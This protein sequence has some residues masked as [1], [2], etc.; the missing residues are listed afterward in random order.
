LKLTIGHIYPNLLNLY[1]DKGNITTFEKRL[2][3]REI[4]YETVQYSPGDTIE[5]SKIDILYIGACSGSRQH[6]VCGLLQKQKSNLKEY[7]K[8]GGA[9]LAIDGGY[10]LLGHY[11]KTGESLIEGLA[12][13]DMFTESGGKRAVGDS[14][15][16]S[17]LS[18]RVIVGFENHISQTYIG[19]N[20]PLGQTISGNG[21]NGK[22]CG[23][24][25][26]YKNVIGTYLHGP[27][28]PKNPHL[29]DYILKC[30]L[31][32]RFG[33]ALL[34]PLDDSAELA[35]NAYIMQKYGGF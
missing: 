33:S 23:E 6:T 28:L 25:V 10:Q 35:A 5:F 22:D 18:D 24:G 19:D 32:Q 13:V 26:V 21:N 16:K 11:Y 20:K 12:A 3:W 7:I 4:K 30:A 15:I 8:N 29:C 34:E 14:V 2:S 31:E 17:Y 9:V 27:L 1:G